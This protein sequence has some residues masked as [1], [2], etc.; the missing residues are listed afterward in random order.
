[1]KDATK[2][3]RE[4]QDIL[5][6]FLADACIEEADATATAA[7]LYAAFKRWAEASGERPV[8]QRTLGEWLRERGFESEHMRKG[9][10]WHG[11]RVRCD[12]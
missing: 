5:A 2:N 9:S 1:M 11:L 10:V 12:A 8:S 3:Y 7:E 6:P 4:E